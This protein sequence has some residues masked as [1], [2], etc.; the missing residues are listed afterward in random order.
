MLTRGSA[1]LPSPSTHGCVQSW[2]TSRLRRRARMS[3][4][5]ASTSARVGSVTRPRIARRRCCF[6][7]TPGAGRGTD[8]SATELVAKPGDAY[9][10]ASSFAAPVAVRA[11]ESLGYVNATD[12]GRIVRDAPRSVE[13]LAGV[14]DLNLRLFD[15]LRRVRR[16]TAT[17]EGQS[18]VVY[19]V[20]TPVVWWNSVGELLRRRCRGGIRLVP[21]SSRVRARCR[22]RS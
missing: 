9:P 22:R 8:P 17:R 4:H 18:R 13:P 7:R 12:C 2:T 10:H 6:A 21:R 20:A 15:H 16:V 14:P 11:H 5:R 1:S 3:S 19:P